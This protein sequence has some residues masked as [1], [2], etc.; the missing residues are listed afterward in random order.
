MCGKNLKRFF[1]LGMFGLF[2][3][4]IIGGVLA[5][6]A[7]EAGKRVSEFGSNVQEFFSAA[8][9]GV[10]F[11]SNGQIAKMFFAALLAMVIFTVISSFFSDV[12]IFIKWGITIAIS[13]IAFI[14]IPA[15]YF[16]A[17]ITSYGAMGLTILTI[18]P[19]L[20]IAV[21]SVKTN[22]YIAARGVWGIY[23]LYYF[24]L[25]IG[26]ILGIKAA[27]ADLANALAQTG[28]SSIG[29][30]PYVAALIAGI[31]M[32]FSVPYFRKFFRDAE[33]A[34][35]KELASAGLRKLAAQ[36]NLETAELAARTKNLENVAKRKE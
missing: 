3:F 33:L 8:F 9:N 28:S 32:F 17:L 12:N 36:R 27:N 35:H 5:T 21:F 31:F 7:T 10:D 16:P 13:F 22:S 14:G 18:I 23:V 20:I 30:Y 24:F 1:V 2:L 6:D 25:L 11:A 34:G 29:I 19:F 15:D 26:N 4:S